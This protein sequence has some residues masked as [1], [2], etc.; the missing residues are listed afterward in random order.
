MARGE[1]VGFHTNG[2]GVGASGCRPAWEVRTEW[3]TGWHGQ[4]C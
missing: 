1:G 2:V 4:V 3:G